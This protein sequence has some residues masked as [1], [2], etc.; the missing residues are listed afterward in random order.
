MDQIQKKRQLQKFLSLQGLLNQVAVV[1]SVNKENLKLAGIAVYHLAIIVPNRKGVHVMNKRQKFA[2]LILTAFLISCGGDG[3]TDNTKRI[4]EL[5]SVVYEENEVNDGEGE[6]IGVYDGDGKRIGGLISLDLTVISNSYY[7]KSFVKILSKENFI[8]ILDFS[9]GKHVLKI[10]SQR[11]IYKNSQCS[12]GPYGLLDTNYD[13]FVG[14][15]SITNKFVLHAPILLKG[16]AKAYERLNLNSN[17]L[18]ILTETITLDDDSCYMLSFHTENDKLIDSCKL[19]LSCS[20]IL[21]TAKRITEISEEESGIKLS[22]PA[23]L[24]IRND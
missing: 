13:R 2:M 3:D 17:K 4:E 24:S 21:P 16:G 20:G 11:F 5:E 6:G 7:G 1:R 22:Y 10:E 14:N 8:S 19:I 18:Y 9:S 23:P 12:D 15:T